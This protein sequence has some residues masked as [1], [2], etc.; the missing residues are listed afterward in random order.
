MLMRKMHRQET[1]VGLFEVVCCIADFALNYIGNCA[2][3][4]G[5]PLS[6]LWKRCFWKTVFTKM[7]TFTTLHSTHKNKDFAPQ[8]PENDTNEGN[9]GCHARRN[10]VFQKHPFTIVTLER[11]SE[12]PTCLCGEGGRRMNSK[13]S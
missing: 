12:A 13:D 11:D 3:G 9:G 8:T 4:I 5:R 7:R 1:N 10:T 6:E 2:I